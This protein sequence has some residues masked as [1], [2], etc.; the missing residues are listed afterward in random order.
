MASARTWKNLQVET[1]AHVAVVTLDRPE[2]LNA[3][4][5]ET[6][7]ELEDAFR[8]LMEDDMVKAVIVTGAGEKAFAAGADIGELSGLNQKEGRALSHQ[9]QQIFSDIEH[10]P[11]PVVAAINGYALGGGAELALACHVRIA[12]EHAR[13]GLPEVTL[14]LIPGYGGTRRLARLT[15]RGVALEMILTG[16]PVD[17][18]RAERT[19]LVN[20]VVPRDQLMEE[21]RR[22][23][24]RMIR[25]GP[26]ALSRAIRAVNASPA[27]ERNGYALEAELFGELC[28][29]EDVQ[30]GVSAFLQKREPQFRGQ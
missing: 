2:T 3:L 15:G 25:N 11:K 8:I 28:E 6:L 1:S 7:V 27:E 9:V 16:E 21:S 24:S 29:S 4:N 30:E 26:L 12:A 22:V 14:G 19:S 20:R 18:A 13:I 5:R 10:A 23:A 17:A